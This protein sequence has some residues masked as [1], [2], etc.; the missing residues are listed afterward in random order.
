[1]DINNRNFAY[2]LGAMLGDGCVE[3]PESKNH[4]RIRIVTKD[5]E[6][7]DKLKQVIKSLLG[8][9][10]KS[11][12][13]SNQEVHDIY[14]H[15]SK[16]AQIC[17]N[18]TKS[19][20]LSDLFLESNNACAFIEGLYDTEGCLY[21]NNSLTYT[22]KKGCKKIYRFPVF[23]FYNTD[24]NLLTLIQYLLKKHFDIEGKIFL[25]APRGYKHMSPQ[26]TVI[27][28][29]KDYLVFRIYRKASVK[30]FS[31]YIHSCIP[32]KNLK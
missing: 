3:K 5:I 9:S 21:I 11:Y 17:R 31:Q 13:R 25:V 10:P 7:V 6:L 23:E 28:Y 24:H 26:G 32:R 2:F 29:S 20:V 12:K 22:T 19:N 18:L 8:K 15:S 1:M 14:F 27:Q 16:Y 4:N 30:S